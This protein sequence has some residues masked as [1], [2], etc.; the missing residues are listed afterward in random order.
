DTKRR[1]MAAAEAVNM[2]VSYQADVHRRESLDFYS[3]HQEAQED[4]AAVR[5]EIEILMRERGLLTSKRASR[6][7]R[8]WLGLRLIA[9]H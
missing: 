9:D 8:P 7:V 1:T 4:R 3:Q 6:P 5:A 2:R